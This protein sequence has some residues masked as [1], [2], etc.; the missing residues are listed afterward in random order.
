M[1]EIKQKLEGIEFLLA[2][3]IENMNKAIKAEGQK[4]QKEAENL[5]ESAKRLNNTL[6][7]FKGK[8][9]LFDDTLRN[10]KPVVEHRTVNVDVKQPLFWI[11]SAVFAIL[12]SFST[13]YVFYSKL[14]KERAEKDYY[15]HQSDVKDWN[16]MKYKYLLYFGD[17]RT[18]GYLKKFDQEYSKNYQEYDQKVI[19]REKQLKSAAVAQREAE[20][21]M[22]EA[23]EAQQKADSLNQ[24]R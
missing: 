4:T 1:E 21:K 22:K 17:A 7:E 8:I 18:S 16:Y 6:D 13:C 20:L 9:G 5:N 2:A 23:R 24:A 15:R 14:S 3:N 12:I 10:F 11:L 19:E